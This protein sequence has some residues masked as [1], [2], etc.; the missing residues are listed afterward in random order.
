MPVM[1]F[2]LEDGLPKV[3]FNINQHDCIRFMAFM[4]E[5]TEYK[6]QNEELEQQVRHWKSNHDEVIRKSAVLSQRPDLPVDRLPAI[7]R[8]EQQNTELKHS[9]NALREDAARY[10]YIRENQCWYRFNDKAVVGAI[11]PYSFDFQAKA[12]LDHHI[13]TLRNQVQEGES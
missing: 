11:F 9:V 1:N 12:M 8:Y 6:K 13:D 10:Q 7:Q 5:C 3:S 4:G 2:D